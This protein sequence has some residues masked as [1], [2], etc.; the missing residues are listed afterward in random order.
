M[1]RKNTIG[2]FDWA[3]W[4]FVYDKIFVYRRD[5][6]NKLDIMCPYMS[7]N[8]IWFHYFTTEYKTSKEVTGIC[9][10]KI[11]IYCMTF[12]WSISNLKNLSIKIKY[13]SSAKS[14]NNRLLT[15]ALFYTV[16]HKLGKFKKILQR[17]FKNTNIIYESNPQT[18]H[19]LEI[20]DKK[21]FRAR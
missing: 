13:S 11:D 18:P 7:I 6:C 17:L 19:Q 9:V 21:D 3:T 10:W 16:L 12:R 1:F 14:P 4:K 20:V 5:N 8:E 15:S 2:L